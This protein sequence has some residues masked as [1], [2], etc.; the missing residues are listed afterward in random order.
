MLMH[1]VVS[2]CAKACFN[3]ILDVHKL[4][5]CYWDL[6]VAKLEQGGCGWGAAGTVSGC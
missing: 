3:T 2:Q 5:G 1:K 4:Y 6:L